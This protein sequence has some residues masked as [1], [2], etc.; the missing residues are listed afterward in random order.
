MG[1]TLGALSAKVQKEIAPYTPEIQ[2]FLMKSL[3][4]ALHAGAH[5][6]IITR[7]SVRTKKSYIYIYIYRRAVD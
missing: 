1:L 5:T 3:H 6:E 4:F 2:Y 7:N